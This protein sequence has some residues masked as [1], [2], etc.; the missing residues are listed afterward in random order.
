M[1]RGKGE[2]GQTSGRVMLAGRTQ[3]EPWAWSGRLAVV[4]A[5]VTLPRWQMHAASRGGRGEPER[6]GG[7]L[8][9]DGQKPIINRG[10]VE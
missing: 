7:Q 2:Q 9:A 3:E 5:G 1:S 10:M 4:L 8:E 6:Q